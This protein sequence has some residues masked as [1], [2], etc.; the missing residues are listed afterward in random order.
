MVSQRELL[1]WIK[2]VT[3]YNYNYKIKYFLLIFIVKNEIIKKSY[4]II[5]LTCGIGAVPVNLEY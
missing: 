5:I 3:I 2:M 4:Q 1:K